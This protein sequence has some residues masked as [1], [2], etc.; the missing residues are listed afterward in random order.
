MIP[1]MLLMQRNCGCKVIQ[2]LLAR[3]GKRLLIR[4]KNHFLLMAILKIQVCFVCVLCVYVVYY[5]YYMC[6]YYMFII[7]FNVH[8]SYFLYISYYPPTIVDVAKVYSNLAAA[9]CKLGKYDDALEAAQNATKVNT[10]W[11][12]G[13]WRLGSVYELK[14]D[15][16]HALNNYEKAVE[17]DPDE[18]VYNKAFKRM[19]ERLGCEKKKGEEGCWSVQLPVSFQNCISGSFA[20]WIL[21]I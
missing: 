9:L 4:M 12:K 20:I 17:N 8:V 6:L 2:P 5:C 21:C 19:L 1:M 16:L 18:G 14:K 11:A 7:A 3:N 10:E 13:Y 15:F